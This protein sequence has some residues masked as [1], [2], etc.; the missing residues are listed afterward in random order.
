[1]I[2]GG[3]ACPVEW[4]TDVIYWVEH[5]G[6]RLAVFFRDDILSN[7]IS[8]Q[9]VDAAGFIHGLRGLLGTRENAYVV[10]AMDAETYG[11]HIQNWEKLFLAEVYEELVPRKET[12]AHIREA[13]ALANGQRQMLNGAQAAPDIQSVTVSELLDLFPRGGPVVPKA[14]SWSSTAADL[15][16]SNPYPLWHDPKNEI[17]QLQWEHLNLCLDMMRRAVAWANNEESKI[18]ADIARGLMDRAVHSCQFWW[19]SRR[20]MWDINLIH[21][22]LMEQWEVMV[23]AYKAIRVSDVSPERKTDYYYRVVVARDLRNKIEDKLFL[24]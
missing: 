16:A 18:Y 19:A 10:T 2:L 20:P 4:P 7:R 8:F 15:A 24:E 1:M 3:V 12:Y 5:E 23:N 6:R 13:K 21:R 11:H 14:S 9:S 22:G 17:H